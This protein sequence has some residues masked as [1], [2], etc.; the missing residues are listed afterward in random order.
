MGLA[1]SRENDSRKGVSWNGES[2][3]TLPP[4]MLPRVA[5]LLTIKEGELS[6]PRE[7]GEGRVPRG[8]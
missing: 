1:A 3:W 4:H 8:T 5:D 6:K 2:N 7:Q